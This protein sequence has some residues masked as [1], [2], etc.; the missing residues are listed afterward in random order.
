MSEKPVNACMALVYQKLVGGQYEQTLL[1][2]LCNADGKD[3]FDL[4]AE[5]ERY[6][7]THHAE[8]IE[9]KC[10]VMWQASRLVEKAGEL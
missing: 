7:S 4:K 6:H 5:A 10:V 2:Y 8:R 1:N 9:G 3:D